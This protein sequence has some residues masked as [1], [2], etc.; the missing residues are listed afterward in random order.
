MA[1]LFFDV[2]PTLD[3]SGDMKKILSE[4]EVTKVGMNHERD[5]IRVYLLGSH[6]IHKNNIT[7]L[8]KSI[9]E[10]IFKGK[11]MNVRIIEKYQLSEQYTARTLMDMYKDS[12][13]EELKAYSLMEYNLLRASKMEFTDD[14]HLHLVLENTIRIILYVATGI[15]TLSVLKQ[16]VILI[17]FMLAAVFLGMKSSSVLNEKIIKKIVII[18]LILSGIVLIINNIPG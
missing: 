14:S 13:L 12:I 8:E 4:M 11:R 15:L 7:Q 10:Q 6:L 5:H 3:V 16:V 17:P 18:L 1:K 9:E 2:F